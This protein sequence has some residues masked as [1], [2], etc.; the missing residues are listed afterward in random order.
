MESK[1]K[2]VSVNIE[3]GQVIPNKF[4]KKLPKVYSKKALPP[5][6]EI[7]IFTEED[8]EEMKKKKR[9]ALEEAKSKLNGGK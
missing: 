3:K 5:N 9:E 7:K 8:R 6:V 4:I 2:S 1:A